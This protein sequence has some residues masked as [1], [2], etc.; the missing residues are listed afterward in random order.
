MSKPANAIFGEVPFS[1][2]SVFGIRR[3]T[4]RPDRE[5]PLVGYHYGN[6]SWVPDVM[7]A[8]CAVK[9]HEPIPH[10]AGTVDCTCGLYAQWSP[11]Q[12]QTW[13]EKLD[14]HPSH[15]HGVWGVLE[16]FGRVSVGPKGFRAEKGRIVA[17]A[18]PSELVPMYRCPRYETI[19]EMLEAHPLSTWDSVRGLAKVS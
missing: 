4:E 7:V 17:L 5:Y 6:H 1:A 2:G 12:D 18:L 3:W 15:G 10:R 19:S 8:V 14:V 11:P 13:W 9:R 16:G